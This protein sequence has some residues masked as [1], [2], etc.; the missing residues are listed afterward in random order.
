MEY[1][2]DWIKDI[3]PTILEKLDAATK[4]NPRI[5]VRCYDD[6]F[7]N[8]YDHNGVPYFSTDE[9]SIMVNGRYGSIVYRDDVTK[10]VLLKYVKDGVDS[11]E[12]GTE[13]HEDYVNLYNLIKS[14]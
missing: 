10:E 14:L 12:E 4:D 2:F 1:N 11:V 8:I 9:I 13:D 5:N 6:E 3:E 7:D